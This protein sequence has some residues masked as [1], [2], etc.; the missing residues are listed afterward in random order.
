[1]NDEQ[2]T[3][4]VAK[5]PDKELTSQQKASKAA[6][7]KGRKR[8][9]EKER[10]ERITQVIQLL[11]QRLS[12]KEIL[13]YAAKTWDIQARQTDAY[14]KAATDY[15]KTKATIDRDL[16]FGKIIKEYENQYRMAVEE[17]DYRLCVQILDR[18]SEMMGLKQ[19]AAAN[20]DVTVVINGPGDIDGEKM[21]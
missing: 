13:R 17:K 4:E 18:M 8:I 10:Q 1:M 3:E 19:H 2:T 9:T 7:A 12:R 11:G 5:T 20:V 15:F 21:V 16:E 14:I 6:H